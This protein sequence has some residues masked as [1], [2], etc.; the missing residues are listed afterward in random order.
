MLLP[1]QGGVGDSE[2][3]TRPSTSPEVERLRLTAQTG[4]DRQQSSTQHTPC[5]T[6]SSPLVHS[7]SGFTLPGV[8]WQLTVKWLIHY[9]R[10]PESHTQRFPLVTEQ[11]GARASGFRLLIPHP[12][13][14]M[15][16]RP[17]LEFFLCVLAPNGRHSL[18]ACEISL[19]KW[20]GGDQFKPACMP[21][22]SLKLVSSL[23]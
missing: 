16:G 7:L 10:Q 14:G 9:Q 1:H 3:T 12:H 15:R 20:V 6:H 2:E 21:G 5:L 11:G 17:K 22:T 19:T 8:G 23:A 13:R 18:E 4:S